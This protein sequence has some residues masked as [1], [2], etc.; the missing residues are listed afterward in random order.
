[1]VLL[2]EDNALNQKLTLAQLRQLGLEQ[3]KTVGTG[4]DAVN[5]LRNAERAGEGYLL[6]LMDCQMPE[7]DGFAAARAVR[8]L[9]RSSGRHTPIVA[10]T[11][12]AA[13]EDRE[14]CLAAGM[15]DCI[16]KPVRLDT[17]HATLERWLPVS[18]QRPNDVHTVP[19]VPLRAQ[20]ATAAAMDFQVLETLRAFESPDGP[21]ETQELATA[22]LGETETRLGELER[23]L[24]ARDAAQARATAHLIRGSSAG[25]GARQLAE[26]AR[27]V[28]ELVKAAELERAAEKIPLMQ[29]E[30]ERV[31]G[32]LREER[33]VR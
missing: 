13:E 8:Q 20:T 32:A 11:A 3:V 26:L 21:N 30:F 27:E 18:K 1:M 17:L 5:A 15:D 9:E 12:S 19:M 4:R 7:M 22:Y 24:D 23:A 16:V 2:A 14:A 31:K 28:E 33:F 10:M 6:V 25:V 29:F